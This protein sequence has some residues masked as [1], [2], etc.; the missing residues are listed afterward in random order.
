MDVLHRQ[1][2]WCSIDQFATVARGVA[3]HYHT[4]RLAITGQAITGDVNKVRYAP[5]EGIRPPSQERL[6]TGAGGRH[7]VHT[8]LQTDEG[9]PTL[10]RQ[11]YPPRCQLMVAAVVQRKG[12]A[13][14]NNLK[15]Q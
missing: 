6:D 12:I 13:N 3:Q 14:K 10:P 1:H 11:A 7:H 4:L 2:Q 15:Q 8:A 9:K 5:G